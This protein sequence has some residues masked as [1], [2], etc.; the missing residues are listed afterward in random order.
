MEIKVIK[1]GGKVIDNDK[2]LNKLLGKI[3][4]LHG[5]V[6]LV[7]GGGHA[8]T[9]L[10]D[11]MG[12]EAPMIEGRRVTDRDTLDIVTMVYGGLINKK[13]AAGLQKRGVNALGLSGADAGIIRAKKRKNKPVDYGFVGDI[14]EVDAERLSKLLRSGLTPVIAPLTHDGKGQLLNTNA[15]SIAAH[16]AMALGEKHK[17]ALSYY[18][19][20]KGVMNGKKVLNILNTD[21]YK[22]L[23]NAG[24]I[25]KG[26]IPKL[27]MGFEALKSGVRSV[28]VAGHQYIDN[29]E[30]G[31]YLLL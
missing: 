12:V 17:V 31:T 14:T 20:L 23:R 18:F 11:R 22:E 16:V 4:K 8:A 24:V 28:R 5:P 2:N 21:E 10:G 13:L 30:G 26:M 19:D 27:D 3:S 1:I 15:D 29:V 25:S 6:V 7:H 9:K